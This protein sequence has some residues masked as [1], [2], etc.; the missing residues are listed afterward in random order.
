MPVIT[1]LLATNLSQSV[2]RQTWPGIVQDFA[3]SPFGW[4]PSGGPADARVGF[5]GQRFEPATG[6]YLLGDG[7]RLYNPALM[8]FTRPDA[9]SPFGKGGLNAYAYCEGDPVNRKDPKG[10]FW[11]LIFSAARAL[12]STTTAGFA[13]S[14]AMTSRPESWNLGGLRLQVG[15]G[16]AVAT[17]MAMSSFG[18][19]AGPTVAAA[20]GIIAG[21]GAAMRTVATV[22]TLISKPHPMLEAENNIRW[23]LNMKPRTPPPP[24]IEMAEVRAP[25]PHLVETSVQLQNDSAQEIRHRRRNSILLH[26]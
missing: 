10:E 20:G 13:S 9:L 25:E 22:K 4:K 26:V 3:Y 18:V 8:R 21:T 17:G 23:F 1:A 24:D 15:G 16:T 2:Q 5:N 12:T 6:G 7:H 19:A 14:V 11:E